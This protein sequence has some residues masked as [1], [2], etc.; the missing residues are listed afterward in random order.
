MPFFKSCTR[1]AAIV[2]NGIT[3]EAISGCFTQAILLALYMTLPQWCSAQMSDPVF[4]DSSL[5]EELDTEPT[6]SESIP[7]NDEELYTAHAYSAPA[8]QPVAMR[9]VSKG[10]WDDASNGLD[11][12]KDIPEPLKEIKQSTSTFDWNASTAGIGKIFQILA[13][14]L[15]ILA[16]AYGIFR[17]LQ[18]P[19]NR[20][21]VQ[22][23]DGTIITPENVDAYIHET[24]LERF[25]REAMAA[26]NYPLC[27]RLYY[28]QVIKVLSEKEAIKWSRE[29]TN[30]DYLREMRQH[31]LLQEFREATR[32]FERV[33]YGNEPL[34][35]VGYALLEPEFKNLL[36]QI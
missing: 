31:P 35:A 15:A 6:V 28:L 30:R 25:L 7:V 18:A 34:D 29:K 22:A 19:R 4:Q 26:G 17:T 5:M 8:V 36:G 23:Q 33:W 24:D 12:S 1:H 10:K 9:E 3:G 2:P 27:I 32:S 13:I 11:Y 14:I 21:V 20:R 16:I